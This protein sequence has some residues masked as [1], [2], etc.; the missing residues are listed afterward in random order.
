MYLKSEQAY[1]E[2][3]NAFIFLLNN[4]RLLQVRISCGKALQM[5][6]PSYTID[7]WV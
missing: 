1:L 7:L 2:R 4:K 6:G 5:S 3:N